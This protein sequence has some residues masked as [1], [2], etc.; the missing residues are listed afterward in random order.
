M[1]D[2]VSNRALSCLDKATDGVIVHSPIL[3]EYLGEAYEG[4]PIILSDTL[5][6]YAIDELETTAG[7]TQVI[8]PFSMNTNSD[9]LQV[10]NKSKMFLIAA[11]PCADS[12]EYADMCQNLHSMENKFDLRTPPFRCPHLSDEF[13]GYYLSTAKRANTLSIADINETYAPAGF[14]NYF[15]KSRLNP[16][17]YIETI[18][19]YFPKEEYQGHV[20]NV[21]LKELDISW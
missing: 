17:D 14:Q 7:Q 8:V 3:R 13:G 18:V 4:L 6:E 10:K 9:L 2:L 21:L 12:C 20:R 11:S 19:N 15:L 1:P 16:V 5:G